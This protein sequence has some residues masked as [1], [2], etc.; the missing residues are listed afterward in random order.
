[1]AAD[2]LIRHN[3]DR[4]ER[5][6]GFDK[7]LVADAGPGRPPAHREYETGTQ[8]AD[9]IARSIEVAVQGGRRAYRDFAILVRANADADPFLRSLNLRGIPWT[10]SGNQ[11]LYAR[12]EVRLCMAFLRVLARPDDS[13][14]LYALAASR[15]FAVPAV[16]L[17][18]CGTHADRR[19]RWLFDVL[20]G[21]DETPELRAALSVE[22]AE[23]IARLMK[24]LERYLGLT[25]ELGTGELLYQFLGDTGWLSQMSRASSVR[26]EAE[27]QNVAR[28]F[29]R[30]QDATRVLPRDHVREVVDHLDA[31]IEAGEGPAVAEADVDVPAVRV[32]TVHKAKGL[33]FRVVFVVGLAQGRFPWPSRGDILELP[34]ALLRDRPSSP[35]FR[36]QEERRL[37]YVAMTRAREELHLTSARDYG[38]RSTRK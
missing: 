27:V 2:R 26:E 34:E 31:L 38:G 10:F 13:V 35:D 32:L 11:G 37:F 7:R 8:E 22:G 3:S 21:L 19:N 1:D 16:D 24:E 15:F 18:R 29:R 9:A 36:L 14:S 23:S 33:E 20:R 28:F 12:P 5:D 25:A 6:R 30:I 17:A 4:L